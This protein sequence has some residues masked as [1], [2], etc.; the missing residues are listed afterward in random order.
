MKTQGSFG[1]RIGVWLVLIAGASIV[2]L[3]T[4]LSRRNNAP[5]ATASQATGTLNAARSSSFTKL[6]RTAAPPTDEPIY[7]G[8]TLHEWMEDLKAGDSKT[9]GI[10]RDA[11]I[12]IGPPA[13]PALR[14][15]L[16]DSRTLN[17]A[18]FALANIGK[19]ALPV[20]L[21][22]LTNGSALT[23]KEIAGAGVMQANALLPFE[24]EIA[25]VLAEC[26]RDKEATVRLGAVN[27]LQSYW[28]RPNV[29]MPSLMDCLTDTNVGVRG[30]AVTVI[31]KFGR[32]AAPAISVLVQLA[33]QDADAYVR[34]RAAES[35]RM[36][37][38]QR[39]DAE[40]L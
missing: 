16:N 8:R 27:A 34:T 18:A 38:P 2:F 26:M 15:A 24:E 37:A 21:K 12:A 25:P 7:Q 3:A 11:L 13:I 29:V 17:W 19:E 40:G 35:L 32:D 39:A 33:K 23:R 1:V 4:Q 5:R 6:K 31:Q 22:S 36:L 30:S 9:K 14:E 10:A 28:K 20:L